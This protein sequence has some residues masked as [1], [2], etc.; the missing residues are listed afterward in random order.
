[1]TEIAKRIKA[2]MANQNLSE[3]NLSKKAGIGQPTIHRILSG[4]SKNPRLSNLTSIAK[5]LNVSVAFLTSDKKEEDLS[6][7]AQELVTR[8]TQS[9]KNQT[10]DDMDCILLNNLIERLEKK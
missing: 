5:V 9:S 1:M 2:L 10:L 8:I 3:F 7:A 6:I 4:E